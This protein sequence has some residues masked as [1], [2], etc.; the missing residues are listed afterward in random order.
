M[1]ASA[2]QCGSFMPL[3][4]S[5]CVVFLLRCSYQGTF[6]YLLFALLVGYWLAKQAAAGQRVG[7]HLPLPACLPLAAANQRG[8]QWRVQGEP[9]VP[10]A[11]AAPGE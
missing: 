11:D 4:C 6:L 7:N 3:H 10:W 9:D 5:A 1:M 2:Q 8:L